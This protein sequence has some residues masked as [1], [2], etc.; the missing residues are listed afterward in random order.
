MRAVITRAEHEQRT[1]DE[2]LTHLLRADDFISV[3][4]V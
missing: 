3:T 2:G 1:R 4:I